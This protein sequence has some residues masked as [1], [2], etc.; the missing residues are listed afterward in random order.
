MPSLIVTDSYQ[1][2]IITRFADLHSATATTV[3]ATIAETVEAIA[4]RIH[5][6]R[7]NAAALAETDS[8]SHQ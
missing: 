6:L 2:T 4:R 3:A 8:R 7:A 5:T 1:H